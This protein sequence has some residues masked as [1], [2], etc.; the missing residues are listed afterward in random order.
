LSTNKQ[1]T[2]SFGL[3]ELNRV[4]VDVGSTAV[5]STRVANKVVYSDL[6]LRTQDVS[7]GVLFVTGNTTAIMLGSDPGWKKVAELQRRL[8]AGQKIINLTLKELELSSTT[9]DLKLTLVDLLVHHGI[10]FV[11]KLDDLLVHHG[12]SFV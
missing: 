12:I 7:D 8:E 11:L 6:G 5:F 2:L 10:S 4:Q 9:P 3:L 1:H